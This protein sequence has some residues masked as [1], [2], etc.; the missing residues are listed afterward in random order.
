MERRDFT[1]TRRCLRGA[2][3]LALAGIA[4]LAGRALDVQLAPAT[5]TWQDEVRVIVSGTG[6]NPS[7]GEPAL[8]SDARFIDLA[9]SDACATGQPAQPFT[10]ERTLPASTWTPIDATV[11]VS[12]GFGLATASLSRF[13]AGTAAIDLPPVISNALPMPL[14]ITA[15]GACTDVPLATREGAVT[16]VDLTSCTSGPLAVTTVTPHLGPPTTPGTYELDVVGPHGPLGLP[17]LQRRTFVV[18]DAARCFP[19][20]DRLCLQDGRFAVTGTWRAFDG[21]SGALHAL[22]L[23]GDASGLFWFFG[24][25]KLELTVKLLDGCA[26]NDRWWVFL[27]SSSNVEYSVNV[28]D[29]VTGKT[30]TYDN[31]LG[32]QPALVADTAWDDCP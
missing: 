11:Q 32:H 18:R 4:P 8:S 14:A 24:P 6:C 31:A 10:V 3:A 2:F 19:A 23:A 29:T 9:L 7:L 13:D 28:L 1:T 20:D 22:P 15:E 12:D 26:V 27:S 30:R 16:T 5:A 21:S 25:D 17:T